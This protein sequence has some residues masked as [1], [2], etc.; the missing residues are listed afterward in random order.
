MLAFA[1]CMRAHGVRD[2]P[3]PSQIAPSHPGSPNMRVAP[4]GGFTANPSSPAYQRASR[5]CRSLAVAS[6]ASQ[7]QSSDMI[8]AQLKFSA[9]MRT[10]GVADYP[11]PTSTGDIGNNGTIPGVDQTSPAFLAAE[12]K[13][14]ALRPRPPGT[15]PP[16]AS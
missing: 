14:N 10:H 16:P 5:F 12:T 2:Y 3:D 13:C 8:D 11:D 7:T 1:Q 6:P 15:S 9:C 4:N